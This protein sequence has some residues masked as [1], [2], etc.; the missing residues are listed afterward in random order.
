M[1]YSLDISTGEITEFPDEPAIEVAASSEENKQ[2]ATYKL[3]QTDWTELPSVINPAQSNPYLSNQEE[4]IA[5][6]NAI[7][8]HA[9]YPVD[10]NV[11]W[12]ELPKENWVKV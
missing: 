2:T 11:D 3:Q 8:Q 6:R 7:R 5:Y 9:I 1:I 4:F 10:G 12:P